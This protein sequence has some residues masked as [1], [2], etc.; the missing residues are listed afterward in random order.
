MIWYQQGDVTIKPAKIPTGKRADKGRV[1]A[2]GEVT[3][4]CHQLT[5]ASEGLLVE[6]DGQLYL[7]VGEGCAE[8]VHEEHAKVALPAGEY[9]IGRV[10]EFDHFAEEARDVRD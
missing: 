5:A 1:L 3:G 4:H 9:L 8:V 2:Y 7:R 6:V 10:Q